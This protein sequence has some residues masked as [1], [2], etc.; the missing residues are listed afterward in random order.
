M[1]FDPTIRA[2]QSPIAGDARPA[3]GLPARQQVAALVQQFEGMLL[4]EMLRDLRLGDGEGDEDG[5]GLGGATLADTMRGEFAMALSRG[6]GF[7]LG[8]IL[9]DAFARQQG[10]ATVDDTAPSTMAVPGI[11]ATVAPPA[12]PVAAAA[13]EPA[14]VSSPFGWREDPFTGQTRFHHGTD[15]RLAYGSPVAALAAG[16]VSF[17]GDRGGYGTTVVVDHGDGRETL[18]AHLSSLDVAVG[19]RV[20]AGQV[21]ARSGRSGRAT[22]PHLHVEVREGGRPVDPRSTALD[23]HETVENGSW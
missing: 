12:P 8:E 1:P 13:I 6:G 17:A 4:T 20:A 5:F 14:A 9:A 10:V 22:G 7:G 3:A 19:D 16:T 23:V 21:I 2:D 18:F 15:L 11:P